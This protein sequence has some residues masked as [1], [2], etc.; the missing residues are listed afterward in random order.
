MYQNQLHRRGRAVMFR[1]AHRLGVQR[2]DRG[3]CPGNPKVTSVRIDRHIQWPGGGSA[4][5]VHF[6]DIS[7]NA[8]LVGFVS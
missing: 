2:A 3:E 8:L 1:E 6:L 4:I 7:E 5:S